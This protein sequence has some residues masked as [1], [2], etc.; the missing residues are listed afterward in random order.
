MSAVSVFFWILIFS[1]SSEWWRRLRIQYISI[2]QCEFYYRQLSF[3]ERITFITDSSLTAVIS[4]LQRVSYGTASR[5][6]RYPH[7]T[8]CF[9]FSHKVSPSHIRVIFC[10]L[11][12]SERTFLSTLE[13]VLTLCWFFTYLKK[14]NY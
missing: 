2:F 3:S 1:F 5:G 4:K 11:I 9:L 10:I 6:A 14:K 13:K 12:K 8:A 7:Y